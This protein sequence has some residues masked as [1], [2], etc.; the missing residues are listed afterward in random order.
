MA[1]L[2]GDGYLE[3]RYG[4]GYHRSLT[5]CRLEALEIGN[6]YRLCAAGVTRGDVPAEG[7]ADLS[8][9]ASGKRS[10]IHL[11]VSRERSTVGEIRQIVDDSIF[12][13]EVSQ[14]P[15]AL[16]CG[17][18]LLATAKDCRFRIFIFDPHKSEEVAY[19]EEGKRRTEGC[20]EK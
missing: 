12:T 20:K 18:E 7:T 5:I 17:E 9:T 1:R 10:E 16:R 3:V 2:Y 6:S 15:R 13:R 4:N 19:Y 11:S 8:S 14:L